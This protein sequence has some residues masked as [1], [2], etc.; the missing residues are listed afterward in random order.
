M[1]RTLVILLLLL[2]MSSAAGCAQRIID[3]ATEDPQSL[4]IDNG[5]TT[6]ACPD[7]DGM[8]LEKDIHKYTEKEKAF[9]SI[10]I[11]KIGVFMI[12]WTFNQEDHNWQAT[13]DL[14]AL[15][16]KYPD[17]AL[18]DT[19]KSECLIP[20]LP[21]EGQMTEIWY[22]ESSGFSYNILHFYYGQDPERPSTCIN[23]M[24][25]QADALIT[26]LIA[27]LKTEDLMKALG[28]PESEWAISEAPE[29][30]M[31]SAYINYDRDSFSAVPVDPKNK[32]FILVPDPRDENT[33]IGIII[34]PSKFGV[35]CPTDEL[36]IKEV[37]LAP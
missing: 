11:E 31:F 24:F 32:V 13:D 22:S 4:D 20:G 34:T 25:G 14:G 26:G 12:G 30:L 5:N 28:I 19:R 37:G 9:L 33:P 16:D 10:D 23:E 2:M 17:L 29:S 36:F 8:N 15:K 27:P 18:A 3:T 21:E 7:V 35:I 1:K 6:E